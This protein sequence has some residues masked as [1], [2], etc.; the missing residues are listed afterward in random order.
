MQEFK[1]IEKAK[2]LLIKRAKTKG[3]Y[4][5]FGQ[6]EVIKLKDKYG[7]TPQ[8]NAFFEW[9]INYTVY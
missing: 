6:R 5:N 2:S 4:E 9:C 8:I 7:N 3:I 1:D